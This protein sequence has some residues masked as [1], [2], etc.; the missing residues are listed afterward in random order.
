MIVT[1]KERTLAAIA[2]KPTDRTCYSFRAETD[3]R[4]KLYRFLGFWDYDQLID[5]LNPDILLINSIFPP[6]K[7]FGTY[8]QNCW[9]EKYV[10][11]K[12]E[13]GPVRSDMDGA[14]A[15]AESLEELQ[16][17]NWPQNDDVDYSKIKATIDRHPDMAIQYG[18]ADVWQRPGLVRGMANFM[19]DMIL[20]PE[21]CHFMSDFFTRFYI[22]DYTR[23]QLAADGRIDIFTVYSDLGSQMAPLISNE[24]FREF[25]F[26]Y[27][28][29]LADA[30]HRING[31]L[32]FHSCGAVFPFIDALIEAGIDILDPIQPCTEQMQPENLAKYFGGRVCFH[33]GV[34]VQQ[35]LS[36][37]TPED[38]RAS[39]KRY[40]KAFA[41]CGFICAPSHFLQVDSSVEN[42]FALYEE[43]MNNKL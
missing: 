5:Y 11:K 14:L 28:Q 22:E 35:V 7:I 34:D 24:M 30:V 15:H 36:V 26:P 9:G 19:V 4:E 27:V 31:K 17:F 12:T 29:R 37:G 3:T 16:N 2:G 33:G 43:C 13:F 18:D 32:F 23:A 41:D 10:Y 38:V 40:K 1:K 42:I 20:N 25:V 39:I 21:Y 6:E 8:C